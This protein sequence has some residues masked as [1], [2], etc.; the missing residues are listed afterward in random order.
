MYTVHKLV[1]VR[2]VNMAHDARVVTVLRNQRQH[3]YCCMY[4]ACSVRLRWHLHGVCAVVCRAR[5]LVGGDANT[6]HLNVE[7]DKEDD[8]G[9]TC[10]YVGGMGD[11]IGTVV[12]V[13]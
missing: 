3:V 13:L 6:S 8:C 12:H 11:I 4:C 5:V 9:P 10:L 1:H 7:L 2:N